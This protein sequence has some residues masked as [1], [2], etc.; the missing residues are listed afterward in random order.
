M[1]YQAKLKYLNLPLILVVFCSTESTWEPSENL[2]C[3]ELIADYETKSK[4]AKEEKKKRKKTEE[5]EGTSSTKA[6]KKKVVE[7]SSFANMPF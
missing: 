4:Q 1:F 3:P 6:K 2:D 7:V 5:E